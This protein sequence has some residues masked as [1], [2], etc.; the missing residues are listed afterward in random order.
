[1]AV[2][3][4]IFLHGVPKL[5]NALDD[6]RKFGAILKGETRATAREVNGRLLYTHPSEVL[7][8]RERAVGAVE[9]R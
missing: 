8:N 7:L 5:F 4:R 6:I 2:F 3:A 9:P 1:M